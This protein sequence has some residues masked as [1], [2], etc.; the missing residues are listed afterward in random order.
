M[1]RRKL[2]KFDE[3]YIKNHY[4]TNYKIDKENKKI[5]VYY[6]NGKSYDYPLTSKQLHRIQCLMHDEYNEWKDYLK[7]IYAHNPIKI[8]YLNIHLK[9][10]QYYLEHKNVFNSCNKNQGILDKKLSKKDLKIMC[11]SKKNTNSCFNLASA[12]KYRLS[13]MKKIHKIISTDKT[14]H[15][16]RK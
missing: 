16:R 4:I 7:Q 12:T 15:Q 9:R 6:I 2:S 8:I 13:T 3:R 10:Q 1:N 5:Y 14:N 11:A